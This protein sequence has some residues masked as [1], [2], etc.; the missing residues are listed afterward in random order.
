MP[1]T[2]SLCLACGFCCNG[3]LYAR[4]MVKP[5]EIEHIRALGLAVE[6]LREGPGFHQPCLL[7]HQQRCSAYPNHPGACRAYQCDLL[8]KY[9]AGAIPQAQAFQTIQYAH[10]LLNAVIAQ[11]PPDY[12]YDQVLQE[13]GE[14][15]DSR[16]G[17]C[18]SDRLRQQNAEL[19][20]AAA[21]LVLYAHKHFG[22]PKE[23]AADQMMVM[24]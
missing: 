22:D 12:S 11:L 5:E 8:K 1:E 2:S 24:R 10:E 9:L 18:G 14:G 20:L 4:V 6:L 21:K 13:M 7:Y 23:A 15:Q 16:G 19:L 17:I 3:V